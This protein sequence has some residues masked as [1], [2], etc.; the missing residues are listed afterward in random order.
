MSRKRITRIAS[1]WAVILALLLPSIQSLA[2]TPEIHLKHLTLDQ[3]LSANDVHSIIQDRKG[4]IWL[5][6]FSGLS[7]YDGNSVTVFRHDSKNPKSISSDLISRLLVDHRGTLWIGTST[8]GICRYNDMTGEFIPF[9]SVPDGSG[10]SNNS[11]HA[12]LEDHSGKLWIGTEG[13]LD[14]FDPETN[15]VVHF[16]SDAKNPGSLPNGYILSLC[17]DHNGAIWVGTYMG[18]ARLDSG[19]STFTV[20]HDRWQDPH[21]LLN[22][23]VSALF[24]DHRNVLWIGTM[25]GGLHSFDPST[26]SFNRYRLKPGPGTNINHLEDD[27]IRSIYEDRSHAL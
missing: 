11:I 14:E 24:E 3:G 13:G 16:K 23:T 9:R 5:A 7:R 18:L 15:S 6:T 10:L 20:Y 19:K 27:F 17:Q 26:D 12:M 2:Q 1:F 8:E 4:F 21:A 25:G 22:G